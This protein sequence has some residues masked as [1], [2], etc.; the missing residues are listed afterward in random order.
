MLRVGLS[1]GIGSGKSTVAAR[2]VQH[3]AVLI[4]ADK[5]AR[6][7]VEPGSVGLAELVDRFGPD[8]VTADG[9]QIGRAHV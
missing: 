5:L 9:S 4:D 7:V 8:I 3:G 6:E 1:G 2:L